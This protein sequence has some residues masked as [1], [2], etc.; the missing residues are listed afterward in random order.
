MSEETKNPEETQ[1]SQKNAE[2]NTTQD[3]GSSPAVIG[4]IFMLGWLIAYL[5]MHQNNPT[6]LGAFHLRQAFAIHL[7]F[8]VFPIA[9]GYI[10]YVGWIGNFT[11]ILY[12]VFG[13]MGLTSAQKKEFKLLPLFGEFAQNNFQFI[14]EE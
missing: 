3:D 7:F 1:E 14:K 10:P 6:K 9:A 4:Y 11:Y 12:L 8:I 5:T 2:N 13:I